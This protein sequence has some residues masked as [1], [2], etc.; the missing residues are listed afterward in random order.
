MVAVKLQAEHDNVVS[1]K[2][3]FKF[4]VAIWVVTIIL[5]SL[6]R[7]GIDQIFKGIH[8]IVWLMGL[9]ICVIANIG[10]G[11]IMR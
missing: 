2:R 10:I 4:M 1:T 3:N 8:F 7:A 5:T 11:L 9:V 6:Q